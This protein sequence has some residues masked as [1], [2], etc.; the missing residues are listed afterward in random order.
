MRQLLR[1]FYRHDRGAGLAE[2]A[3]LAALIAICLI[4]IIQLARN[5]IAGSLDTASA[6]VAESS[7]ASYGSAP[8]PRTSPGPGYGVPDEGPPEP[9]ADS[10]AGD[11][12]SGYLSGVAA[13]VK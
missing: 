8:R 9:P 1:R 7:T 13:H 2:Y 4:G 5:A 11:S 10:V 6:G 3:L 12:A